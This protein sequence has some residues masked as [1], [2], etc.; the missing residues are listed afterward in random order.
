MSSGSEQSLVYVNNLKLIT[1]SMLC[2]PEHMEL[3]FL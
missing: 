3:V 1:H 2:V